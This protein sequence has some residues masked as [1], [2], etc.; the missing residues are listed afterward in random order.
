[1]NNT[2]NAPAKKCQ[3]AEFNLLITHCPYSKILLKVKVEFLLG[4]YKVLKVRVEV[5][6][7]KCT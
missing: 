1:M 4:L 2:V 6:H 3:K 7:L 5:E